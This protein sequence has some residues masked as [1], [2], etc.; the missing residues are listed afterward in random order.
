MLRPLPSPVL[1]VQQGLYNLRVIPSPV[2]IVTTLIP[3][4]MSRIWWSFS[5]VFV[6]VRSC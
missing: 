4:V 5:E 1:H 3:V 6:D 2:S